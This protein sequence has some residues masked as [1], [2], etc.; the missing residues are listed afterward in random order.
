MVMN[1]LLVQPP[2]SP[3]WNLPPLSIASLASSLRNQNYEVE[4][5]DFNLKWEKSIDEMVSEA[6]RKKYD[7]VGLTCWGNMAPFCIEF[8]RKL[9]EKD[10]SIKIV[11]GGALATFMAED[12]LRL[13]STDFV[14][15]GEGENT[16]VDLVEQ[17]ETDGDPS[18]VEGIAYR[19]ADR[20]FSTAARA[21]AN[22]D[23]LPFPAWDLFEDLDTYQKYQSDKQLPLQASKGCVYDCIFCS[24]TKM[25]CGIQRRKTVSRVIKEIRYLVDSFGVD[26]LYFCDDTFTLNEGWARNICKELVRQRINVKWNIDTRADLINSELLGDLKDAGCSGIFYGIESVSPRILGFMHKNI[27]PEVTRRSITKTMDAG[28]STQVSVIYGFPFETEEEVEDLTTLCLGFQKEG[29]E[30]VHLHVLTPYPGTEITHKYRAEIVP[31]P[32]P[33]LLGL[34]NLDLLHRHSKYVPELWIFRHSNMTTD[35]FAELFFDAYVRV[36]SKD[37]F[38]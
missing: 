35:R 19:Q 7:I 17:I 15:K 11:L 33:E 20:V 18:K 6:R 25:C 10:P 23:D 30:Q 29:V 4:V 27:P 24:V 38:L 37:T 3:K 34:Q 21:P 12:L 32:F 31:S 2:S 22:L 5:I 28:I 1:I 36:S 16:I 9:K 14:V 13:G 8:S 26:N